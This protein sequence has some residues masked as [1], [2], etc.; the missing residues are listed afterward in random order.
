[1]KT[2]PRSQKFRITSK[3]WIALNG[4]KHPRTPSF[5]LDG[6]NNDDNKKN[7]DE[8]TLADIDRF[9]FENFKSLYLD[10]DEKND[11]NNTKRVVSSE[12]E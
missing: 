11:C 10:D 2:H 4:C 8:A 3:K 12:E 5:S 9:L 6:K 7:D 1:M